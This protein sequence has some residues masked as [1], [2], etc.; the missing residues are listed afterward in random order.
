MN[1][2]TIGHAAGIV[3]SRLNEAGE[4]GLSLSAI[5]KIPGIKSDEAVAALGWLSR[6]DK[7]QF[8]TVKRALRVSLV[9]GELAAV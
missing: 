5:K 1:H 4:E 3:W 6:E 8:E 7:I 2:E 9:Q